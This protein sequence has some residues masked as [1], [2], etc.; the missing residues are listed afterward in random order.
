MIQDSP[1]FKNRHVLTR[2]YN[3][4]THDPGILSGS[5]SALDSFV[6]TIW[7]CLWRCVRLERRVG[8]C[9]RVPRFGTELYENGQ[10]FL[11]SCSVANEYF[12]NG[13]KH[14]SSPKSRNSSR[15]CAHGPGNSPFHDTVTSTPHCST[16]SIFL[17]RIPVSFQVSS[18]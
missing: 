17:F 10:N 1:S 15:T 14:S 12:R 13:E 6:L 11:Q 8:S 4:S 18:L 9:L 2:S 16:M 3:Q 7:R 5:I